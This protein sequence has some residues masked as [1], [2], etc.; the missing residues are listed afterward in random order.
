MEDMPTAVAV[1]LRVDNLVCD[2]SRIAAHMD[3]SRLKMMTNAGFLS[4]SI[5]KFSTEAVIGS[6]EDHNGC[7]MDDGFCIVAVALMPPK[8]GGNREVPFLDT[9]SQNKSSLVVGNEVLTPETEDDSLLLEGDPIIDSSCFLSVVSDNGSVCGDE[10]MVTYE[11]I[12]DLGT[13]SSIDIDKSNCAVSVVARAADLAE[14][15]VEADIMSEPL[16]LAVS[17]EE[18]TGIRSRPK[19]TIVVLHHQLPLEKGVSGTVCRSVFELDCI[20]LWGF[21]SVCGKRPEMEDA[22]AAVPRFLKIPIQMLIGDRVIDGIN[23]FFSQQT[24]HFFGVYDGHGGSQVANYCRDRLHLA[25]AEEI[26]FVKEGLIVG[27]TKDDCQD[28]WKKVFTNCF[29]KVDAEVGGKANC[30]SVAPET[31]GS[32]AV[33]AII[34]SSHIIV[35]NCGDSRAVLCRGKEPMALSVD[36][37]PNRDDERARIEAAGGKVIQWNGHRVLGVL[38]MSRSIGD[39]YLK[40]W[41]IPEPEV[42]FLP[43][44]K[45]DECLILASDG[46]W[47]VMTNEEACHI[48]RRRILLWHKKNGSTLPSV[49]GEEIDP[50]AQAAAEY[51]SNC[52]LQKGSK[53]NITVIVVDLKAQRKFKSK[54]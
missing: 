13:T 40:P 12:A 23:A 25:F 37:K 51:L 2:K 41:I 22:I 42:T 32:T 28:R 4:N 36:H 24:T 30:E 27:K 46:L 19:P 14:S 3:V 43:R 48:A 16:A 7:N 10:L 21:T 18:E 20:P 47:D 45:D 50:A 52:A 6:E 29:L 39:R 9:I 54:T 8:Q 15:N 26:E 35:S 49:R 53:D 33:V 5:T 44:A 34:C 11:G 31:V 1:P 17:L 38:A